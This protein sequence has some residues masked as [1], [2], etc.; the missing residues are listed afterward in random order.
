MG[1]SNHA[2]GWGRSFE[3]EEISGSEFH[4]HGLDDGAYTIIWYDTWSGKL[5]K[6]ASEKSQNGNLVLMVPKMPESHPDVA[7]KIMGN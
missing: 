3:K 7:F 4:I 1:T 6:S 2:F 5:L